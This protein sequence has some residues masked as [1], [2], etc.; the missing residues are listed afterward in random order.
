M[1]LTLTR[2]V[3]VTLPGTSGLAYVIPSAPITPTGSNGM[4]SPA[5]SPPASPVIGASPSPAGSSSDSSVSSA[6]G[7]S[8]SSSSG[9]SSASSSLP[10]RPVAEFLFHLTRMLTDPSIRNLI[11]WTPQGSIR[12][13]DPHT[14]ENDVLG[15][16]FRHSKYS[17][18]QR[19]LNYF[20]FRKVGSKGRMSPCSY[21]NDDT[22]DDLS[23]LLSIKRKTANRARSRKA[24]AEK[25]AARKDTD[26][27]AASVSDSDSCSLDGSGEGVEQAE[28]PDAAEAKVC[29]AVVKKEKKEKKEGG[30]KK[31]KKSSISSSSSSSDS[32]SSPAKKSKKKKKRSIGDSGSSSGSTSTGP[33]AIA[34]MKE[35][36]KE[37]APLA[38]A[39]IAVSDID[40]GPPGS[41]DFRA[42]AAIPL[43]SPSTPPALAA[44]LMVTPATSNVNV[45]VSATS[46]Q[47]TAASSSKSNSTWEHLLLPQAS[48]IPVPTTVVQAA[49]NVLHQM[50]FQPFRQQQPQQAAAVPAPVSPAQPVGQPMSQP[51]AAPAPQMA[52]PAP[53][54]FVTKFNTP[55]PL[56]HLSAAAPAPAM[57]LSTPATA[58]VLAQMNSAQQHPAQ[59][60]P[61]LTSG[62]Q[63]PQQA[64]AYAPVSTARIVNKPSY[65]V[66][67]AL[68]LADEE[69]SVEKLL[70]LEWTG[71]GPSTTSTGT[72]GAKKRGSF[73]DWGDYAFPSLSPNSSLV[74]LAAI[75]TL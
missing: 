22:G 31:R 28:A 54:P 58:A 38:P 3:Q 30:S 57:T 8:S 70:S 63:Q 71:V 4:L 33:E 43:S 55:N 73:S 48:S 41:I 65:K 17:S 29:D 35:E 2:P 13:H 61:D 32:S 27:S 34:P 12:V 14:L 59:Q 24:Q 50:T 15:K 74:D 62:F 47:V 51:V 37:P 75:P 46:S 56:A 68:E 42:M 72:S 1:D 20:G 49:T 64:Q 23:S 6:D 11:E 66:V 60:T 5:C 21:T 40:F 45:T 36:E 19:Q 16:Y 52:L 69:I 18:F 25:E 26:P 44:P 7:Q 39:A 53:T 67:P 10:S 9:S